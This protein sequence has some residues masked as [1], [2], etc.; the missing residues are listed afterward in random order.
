MF[1]GHRFVATVRCSWRQAE[2]NTLIH[3][4]LNSISPRLSRCST[5]KYRVLSQSFS[6]LQILVWLYNETD[7]EMSTPCPYSK[8]YAASMLPYCSGEWIPRSGGET[9][10]SSVQKYSLMN[11]SAIALALARP[12]KAPIT[13]APLNQPSVLHFTS[14]L[15]LRT[16]EYWPALIAAAVA[17]PRPAQVILL[18]VFT[19]NEKYLSCF[20]EA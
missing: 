18:P 5:Y 20:P 7:L 12:E 1:L 9:Q 2:T 8:G 15:S 3:F 11:I 4:T 16:H 17:Y 13:I 10:L 19:H 14:A 6:A